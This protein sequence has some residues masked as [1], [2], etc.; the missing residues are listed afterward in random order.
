MEGK[1][2]PGGLGCQTGD[3][4]VV[5]WSGAK[6]PLGQIASGPLPTL[7]RSLSTNPVSQP[8]V[9][10]AGQS[11]APPTCPTRMDTP[12]RPSCGEARIPPHREPRNFTPCQVGSLRGNR[13]TAAAQTGIVDSHSPSWRCETCYLAMSSF[14]ILGA[15]ADDRAL[16]LAPVLPQDNRARGCPLRPR[17]THPGLPGHFLDTPGP[18]PRSLFFVRLFPCRVTCKG[19]VG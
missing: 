16:P 6:R 7:R 9:A 17:R 12:R 4:L 2:F 13:A 15:A 10:A 8:W 1:T 5:C 14:P 18:R 3:R 19:R 11:R